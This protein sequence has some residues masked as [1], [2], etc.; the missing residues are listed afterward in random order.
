MV[1]ESPNCW[2]PAQGRPFGFAQGRETFRRSPVSN[3]KSGQRLGQPAQPHRRQALGFQVV[4]AGGPER[5]TV[6]DWASAL[7]WGRD[8]SEL[9]NELQSGSE[10]AFDW[11]V[12]HYHAPV[13]NLILGM[14]GDTADSADAAQEVFLKAFKG[15]RSFRQGS[16]LK[17]WLYRIAIREALNHRR[18]FKRHLQKNVSID[19]EPQEGCAPLDIEDLT[20]TPFDQLAAHEIQ[21]AVQGALLQVPEVFRSAVILR[22]IEGLSYEEVAEVLDCSVGTVKSRILRGRRALKEILEPLL[23]EHAPGRDT[24]TPEAQWQ[25]AEA[26]RQTAAAMLYSADQVGLQLAY[27]RACPPQP[28]EDRTRPQTAREE[29]P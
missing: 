6:S 27:V 13:Y 1:R 20:A 10:T 22:D 18:W 26:S 12:N 29:L 3:S 11:L 19:A 14:L 17:T 24:R 25:K 4:F 7:S 5:L 15:I 9:V 28:A 8:E 23:E 2:L 21:V 16:S